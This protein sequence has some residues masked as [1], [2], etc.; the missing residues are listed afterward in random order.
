MEE[1]QSANPEKRKLRM[2]KFSIFRYFKRRMSELCFLIPLFYSSHYFIGFMEGKMNRQFLNLKAVE[3]NEKDLD[4]HEKFFGLDLSPLDRKAI[5]KY[6]G[7]RTAL[8]LVRSRNTIS[9]S[10]I[11]LDSYF[12]NG[13]GSR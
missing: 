11:D 5:L 13:R 7:Y 1:N 8:R 12:S 2:S 4:E 9:A 10:S 6:S 3:L